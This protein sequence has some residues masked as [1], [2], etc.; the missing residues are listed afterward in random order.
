ML[1]DE[2]LTKAIKGCF[3]E[4]QNEIGFGFPE[5][6]YHKGLTV[7][8]RE[9][10]IPFVSKPLLTIRHRE[11]T[12]VELFPDLIV[13]DRVILELKSLRDGF[14]R[15]HYIQLFS[16]LKAKRA[17]LGFL[18]NFGTERVVD[19]RIIFDEKPVVIKENWDCVAGRIDG[20]HRRDLA[21]AR[22]ALIEVANA[23]GLGYGE[24]IYRELA[25]AALTDLALNVAQRPIAT[26]HYKS[27]Q[28]GCHPIDCLLIN[29]QVLCLVASLKDGLKDFDK[30]RARSFAKNL[31]IPFGVVANFGK[32]QLE[33][34]GIAVETR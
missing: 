14:A 20:Q 21:S 15:E 31:G 9:R 11:R 34:F 7:A 10:D 22:A 5:E 19:R 18:V 12:V 33:L 6:V 16:Y 3:Y 32:T 2:E 8:F 1:V 4:V 13:A 27:H 17:R 24:Q 30:S 29:A 23:H 26:T 28:L 25:F